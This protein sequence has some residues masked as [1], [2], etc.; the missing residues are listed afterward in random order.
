[1]E[2]SNTIMYPM[3]NENTLMMGIESFERTSLPHGCM[4]RSK[5]RAA[6]LLGR[7]SSTEVIDVNKLSQ[8]STS[9]IQYVR[10]KSAVLNLFNI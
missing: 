4:N 3:I 8:R 6:G 1:M 9:V 2:S 10:E 5:V 7:D